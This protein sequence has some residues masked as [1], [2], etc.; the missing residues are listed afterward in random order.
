MSDTSN[1]I[2]WWNAAP[3][4][5]KYPSAHPALLAAWEAWHG[6]V[7]AERERWRAALAYAVEE[8]EGWHDDC[9]GRP[10][11]DPRMDAARALLLQEKT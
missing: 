2:A 9:R 4:R 10:I 3:H 1:F 7:A 11:K 8:A 5:P 6:A